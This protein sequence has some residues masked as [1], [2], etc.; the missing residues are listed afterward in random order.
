VLPE[1]APNAQTQLGP[2]FWL[3]LWGAFLSTLLAAQKLWDAFRDRGRL[4]FHASWQQQYKPTASGTG[5]THEVA[6][7][8]E[9]RFTVTNVGRR[10]MQVTGFGIRLKWTIRHPFRRRF[11]LQSFLSEHFPR[12][13]A[14]GEQME[15]TG[16]LYSNQARGK[17]V[18][19]VLVYDSLGGHWKLRKKDLKAI[20][21][22]PLVLPPEFLQR[23]RQLGTP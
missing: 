14:E 17:H 13:I 23:R 15:F 9:V 20:R 12:R 19:A 4:K 16:S 6:A 5:T 8:P 18:S 21:G 2:A 10:P 7:A 1:I 22:E 11:G 3:G